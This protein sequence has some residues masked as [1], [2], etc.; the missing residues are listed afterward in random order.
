M[1]DRNLSISAAM[2]RPA[3]Q[4]LD[5]TKAE[6]SALVADCLA[7]ARE[8]IAGT[9]GEDCAARHSGHLAAFVQACAIEAAVNAGRVLGRETNETPVKLKPRLFR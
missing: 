4:P 9:F 1:D 8:A 3:A 2:S 7:V 5:Q 6:A